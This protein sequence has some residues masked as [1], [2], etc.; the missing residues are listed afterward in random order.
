MPGRYEGIRPNLALAAAAGLAQAVR[1]GGAPL[2]TEGDLPGR[3]CAFA[4]RNCY[5]GMVDMN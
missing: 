5:P 3:G 1:D 4:C 2:L